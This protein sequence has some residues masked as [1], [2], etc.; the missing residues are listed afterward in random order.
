MF[1]ISA[2]VKNMEQVFIQLAT[3]ISGS[4]TARYGPFSRK[5][6]EGKLT[7]V[8]WTL[9]ST[10]MSHQIWLPPHVQGKKCDATGLITPLVAEFPA[11]IAV[12]Y[13]TIGVAA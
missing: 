8:G 4:P 3:G 10:F 2:E 9:G 12:D 6:A 5:E 11:T 13:R 1:I 7:D